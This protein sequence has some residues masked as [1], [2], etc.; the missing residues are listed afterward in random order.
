MAIGNESA[1]RDGDVFKLEDELPNLRDN[2]KEK[3]SMHG[4][5]AR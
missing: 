2:V 1:E 3:P 4:S 5:S